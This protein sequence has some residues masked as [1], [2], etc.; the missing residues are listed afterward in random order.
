M[1]RIKSAKKQRKYNLMVLKVLKELSKR[2]NT[3]LS[4]REIA[5]ILQINPMAVSRAINKLEPIL[6]VKI[7]SD[8]ESFR[9]KL[10]LI[11]L[12]DDLKDNDIEELMKKV[13][14]SNKFLSEIY[15]R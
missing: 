2:E 12:K 4:I 5:K 14:L 6:D 11:K 15:K 1:K 13:K 3:R 7:G 8:F 10:K 9:L